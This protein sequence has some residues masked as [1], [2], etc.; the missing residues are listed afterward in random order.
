MQKE[1]DPSDAITIDLS[2]ELINAGEAPEP[3]ETNDHRCRQSVVILK[4]PV[5]DYN[6][7]LLQDLHQNMF[8]W[9]RTTKITLEWGCQHL[10]AGEEMPE[11]CSGEEFNPAEYTYSKPE[12][13]IFDR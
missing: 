1:K 6:Y 3:V 12:A 11:F 7:D 10:A 9:M 8:N 5:C 2:L 13:L 4:R